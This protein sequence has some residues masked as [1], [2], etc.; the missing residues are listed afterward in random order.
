MLEP[1]QVRV[2]MP[3]AG[4]DRVLVAIVDKPA[5]VQDASEV[6]MEHQ[7]VETRNGRRVQSLL[8]V[9][10]VVDSSLPLPS[11]LLVSL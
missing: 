9:G 8:V 11:D 6:Q 7:F 1:H 4:K 3:C 5:P 10:L 2:V